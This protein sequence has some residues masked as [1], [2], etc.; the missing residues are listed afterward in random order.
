MAREIYIQNTHFFKK[1]LKETDFI[2]TENYTVSYLDQDMRQTFEKSEA[3]F[4]V[5][6]NRD[7]IGRGVQIVDI[8][9][10]HTIHLAVS[11]PCTEED[12]EVLY[13]VASRIAQK[14]NTSYIMIDDNKV[15]CSDIKRWKD[16]DISTNINIL[17]NAQNV[18]QTDSVELYCAVMPI[19]IPTNQLQKYA[20]NYDEFSTY[21]NEKQHI[22]AFYSCPHF[23]IKD[24]KLCS[25]Y[26]GITDG[27]FIIP[28][29]PKMTANSNE[30]K[31]NCDKA[32]IA[33]YNVFQ[34]D[35]TNMMEFNDF[36]NG[37]PQ[38]K[39]SEFDCNHYLVSP[40]SI[41]ELQTLFRQ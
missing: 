14:W 13:N 37:I 32:L 5:I 3:S 8:D 26:V 19:C 6:Y 29:A 36:L 24:S 40:L 31:K 7:H 23:I 28:K 11:P 9:D 12:I 30:V 22:D 15:A 18:F 38:G 10:K 20:D 25:L 16:R 27:P 1:K 35:N 34:D 17:K 33:I 39:L 4:T 41:Q 21:L 2:G